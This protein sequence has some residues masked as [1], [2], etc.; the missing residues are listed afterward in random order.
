MPKIFIRVICVNG[1][2]PL[3]RPRE[4]KDSA[5]TFCASGDG[6]R[7]AGFLSAVPAKTAILLGGSYP[8]VKS[9]SWQGLLESENS[10]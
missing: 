8:R 7:N 3:S 1:K 6:T 4:I 9:R 10:I 2:Q 5:Y